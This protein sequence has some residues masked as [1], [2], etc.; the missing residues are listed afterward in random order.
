VPLLDPAFAFADALKYRDGWVPEPDDIE[1]PEPE[2]AQRF[3]AACKVLRAAL[4]PV[5]AICSA[6]A[7]AGGK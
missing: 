7:E 2:D 3:L 6:S 4:G 1:F 5:N